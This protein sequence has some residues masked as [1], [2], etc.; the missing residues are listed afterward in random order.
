MPELPE[1]ETT[2]RGIAP[3]VEGREITEVIVRQARLRVPVPA[4]LV[5]RLVGARIG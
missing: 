5:E 1:V 3:H 4:D 2:R